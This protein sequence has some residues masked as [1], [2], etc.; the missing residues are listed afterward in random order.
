MSG[1]YIDGS[2]LDEVREALRQGQTIENLAGRLRC[3]E[4]HLSMLLGIRPEKRVA[5]ADQGQAIELWG[6]DR[7][8]DLI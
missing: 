4:R 1:P 7:A 3:D 8:A 2:T 5:I 6:F